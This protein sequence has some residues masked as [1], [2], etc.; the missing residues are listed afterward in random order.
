MAKI[1]CSN[2]GKLVNEQSNF[3]RHCGVAQ[4]GEES[5]KYRVSQ[6]HSLDKKIDQVAED[7]NTKF[8]TED[9][10]DHAHLGPM[11]AVYFFI[12]YIFY[13]WFIIL[14]LLIGIVLEP[15]I[16]GSLLVVYML[17]LL[18]IANLKYENYRY[19]LTDSFFIQEYGIIF[20]KQSSIPYAQIQNVN[21]KRGILDR[22]LGLGL[23]A[24]ETAGSI[25][26]V[27]KNGTKTSAE[28]NL[29]A[30]SLA[31]AKKLHDLL[32]EKSAEFQKDS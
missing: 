31:T 5:A 11:A 4:I 32:L 6:Y 21:I 3:C 19:S 23:I 7:T 29:P 18:V 10:I 28:G 22:F 8:V 27:S 13:N 26:Q 25:E 2:C 16:F 14:L 15:I 30:V 17:F 12:Q 20:K 24:V 1:Y 9:E